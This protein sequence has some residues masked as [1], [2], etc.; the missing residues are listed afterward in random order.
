MFASGE[1]QPWAE[2]ATTTTTTDTGASPWS[3]NETYKSASLLDANLFSD[4]EHFFVRLAN[5]DRFASYGSTIT[6]GSHVYQQQRADDQHPA[7]DPFAGMANGRFAE[8]SSS[9]PLTIENPMY[10]NHR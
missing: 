10:R 9:I 8:Q 2:P 1:K 7:T 3:A 6:D 4:R 5:D